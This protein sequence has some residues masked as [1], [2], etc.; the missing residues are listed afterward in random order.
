MQ[1]R[2]KIHS[3]EFV[4]SS[5][6]ADQ[7]PKPHLPEYAFIGRSNVGKSSLINRFTGHTKL[8]KTS[9][10]PGKTQLINHFLINKNWYLVDLPGYGYAR[11]SKSARASWEKMIRHYLLARPNLMCTFILI[12][13]RIPL[14]AIDREF[15]NWMGKNQLPFVLVYTKIDKVP[16]SKQN[17]HIQSIRK[18][19]L[20]E[21]SSLPE[22]FIT[23]ASSGLG[24]EAI[25]AF[26]DRVNTQFEL[27]PSSTS[28]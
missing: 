1:I 11:S 8:A 2:M 18:D 6:H 15:L 9:S 27:P 26:V 20:L 14:Q 22:E 23:S 24:M 21:W 19:L 13:S 5:S 17:Q 28:A 25:G 3:A 12:D 10:T 7:C 16:K 4:I